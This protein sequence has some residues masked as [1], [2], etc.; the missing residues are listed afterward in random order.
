MEDLGHRRLWRHDAPE[1]ADATDAIRI[2]QLTDLHHFPAGCT[3]FDVR[4]EKG[5]VVPIVPGSRYSIQGDVAVIAS[6]LARVR[7]HLVILTGDI[8]DARPFGAIGGQPDPSGWR[9]ALLEV[10]APITAAGCAWTYVPGN[11]DD[12]GGPWTR[13]DL[14]GIY[15]LGA[16]APGCI[17]EGAANF[18]H[19]LSVGFSPSPSP[20]SLRLW[21]FDSG[22]NHE[23]PTLRYHT[24]DPFAVEAYKQI[25]SS[26]EPAACELAYF[27]IPLPQAAGLVPVVGQSRLFDAALHAGM[28]PLPWRW[29]PFTTLVRLLGK[30][31][32]VGA[33]KLESG[34][35]DAFVDLG[36]VRAC[37]FGH[38]HINDAVYLRNGLYMA[39]GRVGGTTPPIDWEGDAGLLP[40]EV[41]ARVVEW[42]P[43]A[44]STS[45]TG[46]GLAGK[47][48]TWV[49]LAA[50]REDGSDLVMDGQVPS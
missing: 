8:I 12:D 34:L 13:E 16:D 31:R 33:S 3:E 28:V 1:E 29:Q 7:P 35:F 48:S 50:R 47:L 30:D 36:R 40:F 49:E 15:R 9:R 41:G 21:L 45:G 46:A 4:A 6:I 27:H 18:N 37:F 43:L 38:D 17:S 24:F 22:G 25:S 39:Y 32:I 10:L 11:H 26:H 23:D 20:S 19:T 2:L 42:D 44:Q 5:R 14:L